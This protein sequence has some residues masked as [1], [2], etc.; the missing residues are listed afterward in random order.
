MTPDKK[1]RG[2]S[3][4]RAVTRFVLG[5]LGRDALRVSG[6]VAGMFAHVVLTVASTRLI[7]LA[8]EHAG[9]DT[10]LGRLG[11][12]LAAISGVLLA[13]ICAR[14]VSDR[15]IN[16]HTAEAM[17]AIVVSGFTKV[18]A[19]ETSWHADNFAGATA[20]KITRAAQGYDMV[21]SCCYFF[22][23]PSILL[24][25]VTAAVIAPESALAA[26]RGLCAAAERGCGAGGVRNGV[27]R[28]A[29]WAESESAGSIPGLLP[30]SKQGK[31]GLESPPLHSAEGVRCFTCSSSAARIFSAAT[32]STLPFSAARA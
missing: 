5:Y 24:V 27:A 15:A 25:L 2:S 19:F 18:Q 12:D 26:G 16:R 21:V 8:V 11:L 20:R 29:T 22:F 28:C 31:Q 7:G 4:A 1:I 9:S 13:A 3:N 23:L 14:W 30:L 17:A 32:L 6:F 10:G